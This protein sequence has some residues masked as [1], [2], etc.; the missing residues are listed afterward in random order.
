MIDFATLKGVAIPEGNVTQITDASGAVL[1]KAAPSGV[2][3]TITVSGATY[4]G[5]PGFVTINGVNYNAATEVLAPIG[6][7]IV[8]CAPW[9]TMYGST[10]RSG[11]SVKLN[12]K[13]VAAL[14]ASVNPTIYEYTVTGAVSIQL[15]NTIVPTG[16]NGSN[17]KAGTAIA[18]TEL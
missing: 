10:N 5:T 16:A 11:G 18:I 4:Y 15:Q 17:L 8:C 1:W 12:G 7:V 13:T 6:S 14:N 3:V 2:P 9:V